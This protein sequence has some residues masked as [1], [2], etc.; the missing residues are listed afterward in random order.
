MGEAVA[1]QTEEDYQMINDHGVIE[2]CESIVF[3][4]R[5]NAAVKVGEHEGRWYYATSVSL[6]TCGHGYAPGP[7]WKN[8]SFATRQE[9]VDAGKEELVT[10]LQKVIDAPHNTDSD[11]RAAQEILGLINATR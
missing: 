9:A 2:G 6:P 5:H 7:K 8:P 4:E 3:G 1:R 10:S 11:K